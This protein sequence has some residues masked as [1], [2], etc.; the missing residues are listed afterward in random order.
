MDSLD[1]LP[2]LLLDAT[3]RNWA[4]VSDPPDAAALPQVARVFACSDFIAEAAAADASLLKR[5]AADGFDDVPDAG[6]YEAALE[7][8]LVALERGADPEPTIR[9]FRRSHL[10]RIAWRD[11]AGLASLEVTL[12]ELSDLADGCIR[13][14][15]RYVESELVARHGWPY[16]ANG[17]R[18]HLVVLAMGK[19]GA[20][21]LNL[22]SDID[23]I[24]AWP[25]PGETRGNLAAGG[26]GVA[27][28]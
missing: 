6:H 8:R 14:A 7:R 27:M 17:R 16:D 15:Y 23:L 10:A 5:F 13:A 18:Q 19:L 12:R 25:E 9:A 1:K 26:R 28:P 24:F 2:P 11:L 21:E 20:H 22:S 3:R 4:R